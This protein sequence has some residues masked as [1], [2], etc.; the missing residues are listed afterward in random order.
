[1][2]CLGVDGLKSLTCTAGDERVVITNHQYNSI[3]RRL[4]LSIMGPSYHVACSLAA[5]DEI[6]VQ[7][8]GIW[9]TISNQLSRG[10]IARI[11]IEAPKFVSILRSDAGEL[12]PKVDRSVDDMMSLTPP[13]GSAAA[14]SA[15]SAVRR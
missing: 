6:K 13:D 11:G 8:C 4:S 3:T 1:M 5:K 12:E 2:L 7:L 9:I 10:S 15:G 14:S